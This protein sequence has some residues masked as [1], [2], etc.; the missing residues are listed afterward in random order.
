MA[1]KRDIMNIASQGRDI[2]GHDYEILK[3]K[4]LPTQI[5]VYFD[6]MQGYQLARG[7]SSLVEAGI[8]YF[9]QNFG[10]RTVQEERVN[11]FHK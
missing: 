4:W 8:V 1:V 2:L 5:F 11:K 7:Y 3:L 9:W 10:T 6:P